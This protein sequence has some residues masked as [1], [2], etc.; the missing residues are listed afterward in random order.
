M[1]VI[2]KI[3]L[4]KTIKK[5]TAPFIKR[6]LSIQ[7]QKLTFDAAFIGVHQKMNLS[8]AAESAHRHKTNF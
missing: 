1:A 2:Y 7:P 5:P 6:V 8:K 4:S 3:R